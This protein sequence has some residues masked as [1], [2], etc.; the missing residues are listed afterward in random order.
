[1]NIFGVISV[2]NEER[3]LPGFLFH[4]APYV[5]A[6]IALDDCSSDATADILRSE[7]KVISV[8]REHRLSPAHAHEV[9]NRHRLL[10]EAARLGADWILCADADERFEERFLRRLRV[11]ARMGDERGE[12]VRLLQ[13]VNLWN[14]RNHY[15]ADGLCQ[16]RWSAR[17][18]R[19]PP[20]IT[21]RS[22]GM[23]QP[24]FP[25]ELQ[26]ESRANMRANLYHLRMI[27][28]QDRVARFEKFSMVDPDSRDQAVGY[29]HLIDEAGLKLK[30]ISMG[31][32][33]IDLAEG[34]GAFENPI[35]SRGRSF[36]GWRKPARLQ[37]PVEPAKKS[38]PEIPELLGFD[39]N[40]I[41]ADRRHRSS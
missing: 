23:H 40:A 11:E 7:P 21:L 33:Y 26:H 2:R 12:P 24:W 36:F 41:F 38:E 29:R 1:M 3:Y 17:M 34:I 14:S 22:P 25:Q 13:L 19:L 20:T 9:S 39:F 16:P 8:L 15:R 27:E 4:L 35:P 18:F 32:G 30:R 37:K 5:N 6:I 28:R 10:T 31:R